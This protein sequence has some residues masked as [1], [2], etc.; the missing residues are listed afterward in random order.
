MES[1]NSSTY[2]KNHYLQPTRCH[3]SW[4][5]GVRVSDGFSERFSPRYVDQGVVD[6]GPDYPEDFEKLLKIVNR[7]K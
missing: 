5:H 7:D 2:R 6:A 4:F 1:G 3:G